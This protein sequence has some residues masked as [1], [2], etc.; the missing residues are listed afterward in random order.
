MPGNGGG[1][2]GGD[3][4]IEFRPGGSGLG[5]VLGALEAEVME[6]AWAL[7]R[8]TVRDVQRHLEPRRRLAYTTVMTTMTRL[9]RKGL[10]RRE[11]VDNCYVYS[12]ALSREEFTDRVAR[13][14]VD[15]LL[16]EF[17]RPALSHLVDRLGRGGGDSLR[18]LEELIREARSRESA[19]GTGA[20]PP[21]GP[22]EAA[23]R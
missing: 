21:R 3:I 10:L 14:V 5:K 8:A 4:P 7:G 6:A 11:L 15:G 17:A 19:S 12:P 2:V 9:A 23:R 20:E 18:E 16:E 13:T 22:G 1:V